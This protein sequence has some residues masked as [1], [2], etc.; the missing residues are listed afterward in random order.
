MKRR[1]CFLT[2]LFL[3]PLSLQAETPPLELKIASDG[4]TLQSETEKWTVDKPERIAV[5][6]EKYNNLPMFDANT[7]AY[8]KGR[9]LEGIRA[10]ECPTAYALEPESVVVREK[11]QKDSLTYQEGKDYQLEHVWANLGRVPNSRIKENQAV[12]IDYAY[13]KMRLDSLVKTPDGKIVLK[14]GVSHVVTPALP[15]LA[16]GETRLVNIWIKAQIEKLEPDSIFPVWETKYPEPKPVKPSIAEQRIPKTMAKL[17]AGETVTILAWGDSVTDAG[18]LPQQDRW[19]EQFVKRLRNKFP[20]ATIV[21]KTEAW[22]GRNTDSY[23]NEPP[24]SPKNYQEKVLAV[25]P[26]LF[27]SEFV[28]DSWMHGEVLEQKYSKILSE[29]QNVGAEWIILTPHYVRG[30]WMGLNTEKNIDDDPRPYTK[31]LR[32]FT[33]KHDIALADGAKR[34]GRLWRQG[35]PYST[36]MM[37]NINHPNAFGMSLFADALMELFE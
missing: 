6:A 30:D 5:T 32:V 8:R 1:F 15:K 20:K 33:T 36:L 29:F 26:D 34:Y 12:Y 35:I 4:W 28:N 3:L 11:P 27:V 10:E 17:N 23:R 18:Y 22:G 21:L 14:K 2:V 31:S 19:Q 25:K 37:N 13:R 9:L 16:E 24:G 7:A